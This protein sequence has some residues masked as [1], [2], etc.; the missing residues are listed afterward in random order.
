MMRDYRSLKTPFSIILFF[1]HLS[2]IS[3]YLSIPVCVTIQRLCPHNTH[4]NTPMPELHPRS[5]LH[6]CQVGVG[7]GG[8]EWVWKDGG[9]GGG[10]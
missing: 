10:E 3:F 5:T 2:F 9:W 6:H 4:S 1:I 7:V 8:R